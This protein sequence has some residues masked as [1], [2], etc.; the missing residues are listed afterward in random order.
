MAQV[1][2][3]FKTGDKC[4][5]TGSYVFEK[6]TDGTTTPAPTQN[7]RVIPLKQGETFPPIKSCNKGAWWKLQRIG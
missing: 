3:L 2:E 6:Y 1:G 7:E 4:S 5:A